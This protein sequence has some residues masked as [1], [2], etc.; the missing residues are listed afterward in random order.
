MDYFAINQKAWDKRAKVH[1]ASEMYDVPGFLRGKSSLKEIVLAEMPD[2]NGKRLLHLQ[3]HFGLDTMSWARKGAIVTGVD[4]SPVAIEKAN[5]IKKQ[6]GLEAE[7]ICSDVYTFGE[8]VEPEYDIVFVSYGALCWLPD[9]QKWAETVS[10]SLKP[11]GQLLLVEFHPFYDMTC[12]YSYFSANEPDVDEEGTY[13]ENCPGELST[14]ASWPH[15]LSET[16]NAL[17][18]AGITIEHL[19]EF[20]YSPCN[21]FE[22]LEEREK[23][24]FYVA[25]AKHAVPLVYS[26]KGKKLA[27]QKREDS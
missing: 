12:G 2:V 9:L 7:F 19:N 15:S 1:V 23:G 3:C 22:G 10:K 5:E 21:C 18:G 25:N 20:A 16:I 11:G 6:A 14:M 8:R 27:V 4:F 13:T 26:I 24:R 17:I